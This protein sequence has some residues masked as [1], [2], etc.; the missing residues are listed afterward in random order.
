M[1]GLEACRPIL[2]ESGPGP[3]GAAEARHADPPDVQEPFA[4]R[5]RYPPVGIATPAVASG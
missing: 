1:M 2:R 4:H 3:N 5:R